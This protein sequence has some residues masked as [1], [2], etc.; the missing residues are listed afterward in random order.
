MPEPTDQ[1]PDQPKRAA[2]PPQT[3]GA[4]NIQILAGVVFLAVI[5][6]V[7]VVVVSGGQKPRTQPPVPGQ[8]IQGKPETAALLKGIPQNGYTLGDPKAPMQIVEFLDV[9]CPYCQAHQIDEQPTIIDQLVKTGKAKLTM[10]PLSFLGADSQAGRIVLTRLAADNHAWDFLNLWYFNQGHEGTGYATDTFL[11]QLVAGVPGSNPAEASRV[12]D[13]TIT[14]KLA[15]VDALAK[16][17][18]PAGTPSF[19]IGLSSKPTST[20]A[21]FDTTTTNEHPGIQIVRQ[22]KKLAKAAGV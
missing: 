3:S 7:G 18:K 6:V 16:T 8:G 5:A 13:P 21:N 11:K 12:A 2:L 15:E 9:Q 4:R 1:T 19:Y 20:Y 10:E 22:T 14:A 17:L